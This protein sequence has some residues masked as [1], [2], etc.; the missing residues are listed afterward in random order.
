MSSSFADL[1]G[2]ARKTVEGVHGTSWVVYPMVRPKGPNSQLERAQIDELPPFP[3]V[4]LFYV[5]S[6][7]DLDRFRP[8][9]SRSAG[10]SS[11]LH[12]G[13]ETTVSITADPGAIKNGYVLYSVDDDK[14]FSISSTNSDGAGNIICEISAAGALNVDS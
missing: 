11:S 7:G 6:Q 8:D 1:A 13:Q 14:W 5:E 12:K 3:A 4:G 10:G 9:P 2:M